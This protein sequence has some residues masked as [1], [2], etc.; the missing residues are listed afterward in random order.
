[1]TTGG[2]VSSSHL[3]QASALPRISDTGPLPETVW[4]AVGML[5]GLAAGIAWNVLR[6]EKALH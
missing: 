1:M 6:A 4:F 3:P 5:T 2:G